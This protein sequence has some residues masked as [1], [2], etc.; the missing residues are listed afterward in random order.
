MDSTF[1]ETNY[2]LIDSD[3]EKGK[4]LMEKHKAEGV[5]LLINNDTY[6]TVNG[7]SDNAINELMSSN[8]D[9]KQ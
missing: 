3:S 7:Y 2:I 9:S 4:K 5:P 6:K 8:N 1:G